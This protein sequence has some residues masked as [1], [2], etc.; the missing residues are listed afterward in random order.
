MHFSKRKGKKF[1]HVSSF[2][3][4]IVMEGDISFSMVCKSSLKLACTHV[5]RWYIILS[6]LRSEQLVSELAQDERKGQNHKDAQFLFDPSIF[7]VF[8]LLKPS[9]SF[10]FSLPLLNQQRSSSVSLNWIFIHLRISGCAKL[11]S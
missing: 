7:L 11:P 2:W 6:A 5:P 9:F 4:K 8:R 10:F 3:Y 1:I